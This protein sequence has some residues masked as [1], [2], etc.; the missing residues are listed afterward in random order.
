MQLRYKTSL[1]AYICRACVLSEGDPDS[2]KEA[3]DA[4]DQL[5]E[6]EEKSI[7]NTAKEA[8]ELVSF[9]ELVSRNDPQDITNGKS[10]Q[11]DVRKENQSIPSRQTNNEQMKIT[12]ICKFYARRECKNGRIGKNCNFRHPKICPAF[13]KNG[14]RRGGCSKG[15]DCKDYHPKACYES[16]ERKECSRRDC[17]FYHLNGTKL[18]FSEEEYFTNPDAPLRIARKDHPAQRRNWDSLTSVQKQS[19]HPLQINRV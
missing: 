15:K 16:M 18:T 13:S 3:Q 11:I 4:I 1:S 17:R 19:E 7:E 10:D 5:L 14:N 12:S 6:N 2:L 8:D 9:T